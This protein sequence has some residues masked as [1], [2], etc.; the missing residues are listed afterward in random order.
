MLLGAHME[1]FDHGPRYVL[2]QQPKGL[3]GRLLDLIEVDSQHG[4]AL[5]AALE[6]AT[7][8]SKRLQVTPESELAAGLVELRR[9][10]STRADG[11]ASP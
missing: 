4:A 2:E 6:E 3:R 7:S 9:T 10:L 1:G 5:E 8:L 11:A